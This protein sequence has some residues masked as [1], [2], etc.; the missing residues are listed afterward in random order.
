MSHIAKV[1]L[2]VRVSQLDCLEKAAKHLGVELVRDQKT[3]KHFAG[4]TSSCTHAIRVPGNNKAYEVGVI[5][6]GTGQTYSLQWDQWA[7]GFGMVDKVGKDA[8]KLKQEYAVQ[9]AMKH[10]RAQGY[11]VSR[12]TK[13]DGS[14]VLKAVHS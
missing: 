9:V 5:L 14:V 11:Q 1:D 10:A 4:R 13:Q 3:F 6:S 2:E 7:S 8:M 12:Q